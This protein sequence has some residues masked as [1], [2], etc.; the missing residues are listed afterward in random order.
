MIC[1]FRDILDETSAVHKEWK[2]R[3]TVR[4]LEEFFDQIF[5]YG[6]QSIFDFGNEYA[7]PSTVNKK[8]IYTGY[9]QPDCNP[10]L[11]TPVFSFP[12]FLPTVTFTLGGGGDGWEYLEVFLDMLESGV[13]KS[14][15]NS[16]ILT[17]PFASPQLVYRTK[18][19]AQRRSDIQ[20]LEFIANTESLFRKSNLVI[21]MGGYN[22][23]CELASLRK[24]PLILPRVAP[25]KEQLIRAK[26]FQSQNFCDYIHPESLT[27]ESLKEKILSML[28]DN[29]SICPPEF[30]TPGLMNIKKAVESTESA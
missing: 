8:L 24:Y 2:N 10:E 22:S 1:G 15:F 9:I 26:V 16:V 27:P 5:I 17:G 28:E 21:S 6:D 23:S 12:N 19:L 13:T 14:E 30:H 3:N 20:C 4:A 25:R 11:E 7:L 29:F 18:A